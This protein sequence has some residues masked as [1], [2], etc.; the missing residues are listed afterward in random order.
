MSQCFA[1][2]ERNVKGPTIT[3]KKYLDT[4]DE[5]L[6][7]KNTDPP[8]QSVLKF[9]PR[10][11]ENESIDE[12]NDREKIDEGLE[13]K[14]TESSS[15]SISD[16]SVMAR[17]REYLTQKSNDSD[18]SVDRPVFKSVS[19]FHWS[20][21]HLLHIINTLPFYIIQAYMN[22]NELSSYRSQLEQWTDKV[23]P[24]S[25]PFVVYLSMVG[26][27]MVESGLLPADEDPCYRQKMDVYG[28]FLVV[29]KEKHRNVTFDF[30]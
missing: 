19:L 22:E 8:S 3:L 16:D 30:V 13:L 5:G 1:K 12:V 23:I 20:I 9:P 15:G 26:W 28:D 21:I 17:A 25:T 27:K 18:S 10:D 6:E 14:N 29:R 24:A 7:L 2:T 4:I 11:S